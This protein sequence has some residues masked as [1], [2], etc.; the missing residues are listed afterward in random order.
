MIK[1]TRK[2]EILLGITTFVITAS[3]IPAYYYVQYS[4]RV[5][6]WLKVITYN[7][8][9]PFT[10]TTKSSP[11]EPFD[12]RGYITY[13]NSERE[14]NGVQPLIENTTLDK[15]AYDHALDEKTRGYYDHNTPE[16]VT[17][18]AR[19]FEAVPSATYGG[20]NEDNMCIN[21]TLDIEINRFNSSKPHHDNIGFVP[22][23][24]STCNGHLVIDFATLK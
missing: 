20:E 17:S 19:I 13:M 2:K 7:S 1:F 18:G 23:T 11:P 22:T 14:K 9:A 6:R 15:I 5:P 12:V 4:S 3:L 10:I 21:S 8:E 16:G 24:T